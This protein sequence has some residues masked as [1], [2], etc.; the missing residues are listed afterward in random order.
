M[1]NSTAGQSRRRWRMIRS[2]APACQ[3]R[4]ISGAT[5]PSL[6]AAPDPGWSKVTAYAASK[7]AV[8]A[9]T[10]SA[11]IEV[12]G[13]DVRVNA[14][15]PGPTET[16][17]NGIDSSQTLRWRNQDSNRWSR[18]RGRSCS[19]HLLTLPGRTPRRS[20]PARGEPTACAPFFLPG[21]L[22]RERTYP[23]AVEATRPDRL[24]ALVSHVTVVAGSFDAERH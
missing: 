8:E 16:G 5:A 24:K 22:S 3:R 7:H 9:L 10:T 14:V 19:A 15:A 12:A 4:P 11:A 20:A 23:T 21:L 6:A 2:P 17:N 1:I 18:L 13:S